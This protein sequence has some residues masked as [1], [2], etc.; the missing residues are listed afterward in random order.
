MPS[1]CPWSIVSSFL[2][3]SFSARGTDTLK[4]IQGGM[5]REL[6][7]AHTVENRLRVLGLLGLENLTGQLT[8]RSI[9]LL[10]GYGECAARFLLVM[11]SK[12]ARG[13]RWIVVEEIPTRR[14]E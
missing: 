10:K 9:L 11:H 13:N 6:A 7:I 14:Q 12:R 3:P 5:A 2:L 1:S 4:P 8:S